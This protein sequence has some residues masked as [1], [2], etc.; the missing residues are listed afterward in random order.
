MREKLKCLELM[1]SI[2]PATQ[3]LNF[4]SC[5]SKFVEVS[6]RTFDRKTNFS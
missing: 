1:T 3:E 2:Q 4:D 6:C 5:A